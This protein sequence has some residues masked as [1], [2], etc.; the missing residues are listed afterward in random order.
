MLQDA[1]TETRHLQKALAKMEL[2]YKKI[3]NPEKI[4]DPNLSLNK[5]S[6]T[7]Y[8]RSVV[9]STFKWLFGGGGDSSGTTKQLK[10]NIEIL[11]QN[12]NLQ[13]GQIKQWLKMN[14]VN[15]QYLAIST[16]KLY[17]TFPTAD[18]IFS[19]RMSSGSFCKINNAIYPTTTIRSCEYALFM[20]KHTLDRASMQGRP[21]KLH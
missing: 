1:I 3:V 13:Q 6:Q 20:G 17:T 14:S 8:K 16:D 19:C 11:K 7:R 2:T 5:D 9:R 10:E 4:I 15:H 12:Q 21:C 18:E